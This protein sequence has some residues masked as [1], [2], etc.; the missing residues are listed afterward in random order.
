MRWTRTFIPTLKEDPADA[1]MA[2]HRLMLRAGLIRKLSAGVY[3][4]LP[5][6]WRALRKASGLVRGEM[7][8]AGAV[9]VFLPA[10]HPLELWQETGRHEVLGDVLLRFTDRHGRENCLG[11]TH[12]EVITDIVRGEL[13]SYRQ[14]PV[15]LYQIQTKFRDEP[16]PRSGVLRSREFLMKDAYSFDADEAGLAHSYEVMYRAYR[17]IFALAG[18]A[19][20]P[21]EADSGAIGGAVSAEFMALTPAGEDKV[22]RCTACGYAANTERCECPPP[23]DAAPEPPRPMRE[24]ATPGAATIEQVSAFLKVPPERLVKTLIYAVAG[25]KPE[26]RRAV[27]VL[28]RGDHE[29]NEVKLAKLFP[30][31]AAELADAATIERVTGAP[32]GF[33]GPAGLKLR[34]YADR[35]VAGLANFAT[36]ANKADA[37]LADVNWGRDLPRPEETYDLRTAGAGDSCPK[38]G[39]RL[40]LAP[41]IEL[42]HVFQLG[43][44]YSQA[45]GATFL[46]KEGKSHPV[47]MGCYGI[48]V[49]RILA[50]AIELHHDADGIA[51]PASI[52]P[53]EVLV[54]AASPKPEGIAAAT[55]IYEELAAAGADVL[56]DDREDVRPGVK[57]KDADLIGFPL[58]IVVGERGLKEGAVELVRRR[59]KEMHKVPLDQAAA[60]ALEMLS[61]MKAELRAA[62]DGA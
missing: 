13:R 10:L 41:G 62:A 57:F 58:R 30:G 36:G 55:K 32:V 39:G 29:V 18:V 50:A 56:Y 11:P 53:Y 15:T 49:N 60:R 48:G 25:K 61:A 22:A 19:A 9:E 2:S 37:H 20:T 34:V 6:G 17:R 51:W 33:A 7:D 27:A 43:T 23:P 54:L 21:V 3:S 14:M 59:D 46:D 12:E 52:A 31:E 8:R 1:P 16:R 35:A 5:L 38:C 44:K 4:Y 42:G 45:M 28:V 26:S 24:V 40:E 47:L